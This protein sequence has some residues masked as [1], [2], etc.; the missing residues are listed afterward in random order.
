MDS[1]VSKLL[2]IVAAG[3]SEALATLGW[4]LYLIERFY[5][6]HTR[7]KARQQL[8]KNHREDLNALRTDYEKLSANTVQAIT[9]FITILE[10]LRD[11]G[12]R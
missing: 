8:E 12:T 7:E 1:I 6:S 10:V 5:V 3:G 2:D 4:G 11:R 9:Q